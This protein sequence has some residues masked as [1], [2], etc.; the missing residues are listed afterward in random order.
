M[1][2]N[3]SQ[4]TRILELYRILLRESD[5]EHPLT[6]A[7]LGRR[8]EKLG[9]PANRKTVMD[10][11][12]ALSDAGVDLIS[13]RG[14]GG[15]CFI[16]ART[17]E[18]AELKL[19]LDAVQSSRFISE[20]RSNALIQKLLAQTSRY[21]EKH[22]GRTV[23][24][25]G[26]VK[27]ENAELL[28]T[29]DVIHAAIL[30]DSPISFLYYDWTH[31]HKLEPRHGGKRYEVSPCLLSWDNEFYY[32]LAYD[33]ESASL[34]HYRVDK[35]RRIRR[36][37]G[38]R[39]GR[40]LW[41]PICSHP[42]AYE[43]ELFGKFS[44]EETAVLLSVD[45]SLAGVIVDRFGEDLPFLSDGDGADTFRVSVKVCISPVFLSWVMQFGARMQVLA[46]ESVRREMRELARKIL[47]S[48][49]EIKG[50]D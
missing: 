23:Y 16:G 35:M 18:S 28:H 5:E 32:L 43:N 31:R 41:E 36:E 44:G 2:K 48:H 40:E 39:Q 24:V 10:D 29:V 42:A 22:L 3:A 14:K 12:H 7:D 17:F 38:E 37:E 4:K 11:L 9:M 15:G 20:K 49:S 50:E 26:R 13:S 1:P 25:S 21:E 8:L 6:V 30:G 47:V 34:R 45:Q 27:S 19:L 33:A 46:P